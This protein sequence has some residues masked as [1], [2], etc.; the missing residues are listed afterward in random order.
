MNSARVALSM[1]ADVLRLAKREVDAGR[2]K[3]LSSFVA[4]AIDEKLRRDELTSILD[5]MDAEHGRPTR[6]ATRTAVQHPFL[7]EIHA[8]ASLTNEAAR[9]SHGRIVDVPAKTDEPRPEVREAVVAATPLDDVGGGPEIP[10]VGEHPYHR[11]ARSGV[12]RRCA[13]LDERRKEHGHPPRCPGH[14]DGVHQRFAR[15]LGSSR[16]ARSSCSSRPRCYHADHVLRRQ[17]GADLRGALPRDR[18]PTAGHHRR[19]DPGPRRPHDDVAP[20]R[21]RTT[22]RSRIARFALHNVD[23]RFDNHGWWIHQEFE[24]RF[25]GDRL[26]VLDPRWAGVRT[27]TPSCRT[28]VPSASSST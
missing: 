10:A 6:A 24:V 16:L 14:A 5:A 1:P 17:A 2:A 28:T 23:R 8:A 3:S 25:P 11:R 26:A 13:N 12:Q 21:S 19:Q 15:I 18:A 7:R 27:S 20:G 22:T 9:I 4:E